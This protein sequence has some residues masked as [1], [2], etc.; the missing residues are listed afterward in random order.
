MIFHF[1]SQYFSRCFC[2]IQNL[3]HNECL[4]SGHDVSDGGLVTTVLEMSFSGSAGIEVQLDELIS[5]GQNAMDVL[6]SEEP[7]VV[8]EV[9]ETQI[10]QVMHEFRKNEIIANKIGHVAKHYDIIITAVDDIVIQRPLVSLRMIW[11]ATSLHLEH[12]QCNPECVADEAKLLETSIQEPTW[13]IP[14]SVGSLKSTPQNS[15]NITRASP[16]VAI[17]REEGSNGDREM[18]SSLHMVGFD[19]YDVTMYDL[20]NG[21]VDLSQFQGLVFVG[22]FSYAD[23]FG[24]AKGWAALSKFN[25]KA[26]QQLHQFRVRAD[27]FS[28][29]VCNGCQLM[30]LL[31]W[32]GS[33]SDEEIHSA[34]PNPTV[35]F[36]R[37]KSGR[38]E[39]RFVQVNVLESSSIMLKGMADLCMG[40]WIAHGE[41]RPHFVEDRIMNDVIDK[42]LAPIRYV[43]MSGLPTEQYPFNPNGAPQG[44]AGISSI[45]G[46]HLAMMPHPERS[47]LNWQ[48]PWK[49]KNYKET[50][51]PWLNMFQNAYVWCMQNKQ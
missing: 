3:V 50:F 16:R 32:V 38:F 43:N 39:S 18:V 46:R 25:V 6:F 28:L 42:G 1:I 33:A 14:F 2:T 36:S 11:E 29:G 4:M 44:I 17:L 49:P 27:T 21:K 35:R 48:L 41:G 23:V 24:S 20:C 31:G 26:A 22:G 7:G 13:N 8:L 40:I 19:V 15:A 51:S 9:H 5:P 30:A 10:D 45:D 12:L 34:E 47:V 37:N